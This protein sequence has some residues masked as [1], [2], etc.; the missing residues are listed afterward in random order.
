MPEEFDQLSPNGAC[1]KQQAEPKEG[2]V[3]DAS[4]MQS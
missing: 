1:G 3:L 2:T 4:S